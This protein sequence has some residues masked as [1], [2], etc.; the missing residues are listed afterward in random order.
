[1]IRD[2]SSVMKI[3]N[4]AKY[5]ALNPK[6]TFLNHGSFGACPIP[7]LQAQERIRKKMETNPVRFFSSELDELLDNAR[8][9]LASFI[10]AD[11]NDLVFVPN[12]TTGV[13][14]VL[15]SFSFKSG[16][17][18]LTTNHAYNACRNALK[19]IAKQTGAKLIEAKVPF[20]IQSPDQVLERIMR[21]VTTKTKLVFIDHATSPTALVFPVEQLV[22]TLYKE[23]IETLVDGAHA[24]GMIPLNVSKI[25]AAFYTGNCHKWLCAPKGAGFLVVRKDLKKMI[26]PLSISHGYKAPKTA[27][28]RFHV[29]FDWTGTDDP[30]PY[31]CVPEAIKFMGSLLKGGWTDLMERNRSLALQAREILCEAL[32]IEPPCSP[33]MI[34]SMAA[35]PLFQDSLIFKSSDNSIGPVQ[36]MIFEKYGIEAPIMRWPSKKNRLIRISAQIY[37]VPRHY[38]KLANA[39]KKELCV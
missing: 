23:G 7:V 34:G 9:D 33:E 31:L 2:N 38:K 15:R 35:L 18:I 28:P 17:E 25:G 36:S 1:M 5:W 32:S 39:L 6:I 3:Q 24:P 13:N 8:R 26:H 20:P 30:S 37:N 22:K 12:A 11:P 4:F 19:F 21:K 10:G 16:D 29:E 27:R 14:T